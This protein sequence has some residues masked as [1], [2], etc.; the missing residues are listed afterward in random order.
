MH[1]PEAGA[2][3]SA[4][5]SWRFVTSLPVKPD[6]VTLIGTEFTLAP[7]DLAR[8]IPDLYARSNG[9]PIA[10][11]GRTVAS[12]DAEATIWRFMLNGP[13]ADEAGLRRGVARAD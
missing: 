12:Y 1:I 3:L 13:F 7:L 6:P 4:E 2:P 9:E 10:L 8:D 11:N 5:R